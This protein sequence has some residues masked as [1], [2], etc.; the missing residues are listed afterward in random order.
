MTR[1][2]IEFDEQC[3]VIEYFNQMKH[4]KQIPEH[5][6]LWSNR[7]TQKLTVYQQ[8]R[9][10]RSGMKKGIPDLFLA[11]PIQHYNGLFIEMKNIIYKPKTNKSKGGLSDEQ[12]KIIEDLTK[13]NYKCIVCYSSIEAINAINKY[14]ELE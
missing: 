12:I 14:L 2:Y 4:F 1:I 5:Y 10:K 13:C 6:Q 7:N 9:E 8:Q 3:K 11:V